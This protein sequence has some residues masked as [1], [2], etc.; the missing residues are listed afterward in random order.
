MPPKGSGIRGTML[1]DLLGDLTS[2]TTII[3]Q[4]SPAGQAAVQHG[5]TGRLENNQA[6]WS[7]RPRSREQ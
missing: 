3:R 1:R 6:A 2:L 4:D 7:L 5:C